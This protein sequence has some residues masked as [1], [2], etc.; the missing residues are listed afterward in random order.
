MQSERALGV[1][2]GTLQEGGRFVAAGVKLASGIRGFVLN[3]VTIAYSRPAVTNL[4][5]VDPP[6]ALMERLLGP[7]EV[8]EHLSGTAH[9]ARSV[10]PSIK[11]PER[12]T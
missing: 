11:E 12:R 6:W 7:L 10:K 1:A 3:P 5:G 2:V 8:E 4:S 9:I